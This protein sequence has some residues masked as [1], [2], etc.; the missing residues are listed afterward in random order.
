[1]GI[2]G[3]TK[4]RIEIMNLGRVINKVKLTLIEVESDQRESPGMEV[5]IH[6][7]EDAPYEPQVRIIKKGVA[8]AIRAG[9]L[10]T[11]HTDEAVEIGDRARF[12]ALPRH[13]RGNRPWEIQVHVWAT[14][15]VRNQDSAG[16]GQGRYHTW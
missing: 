2:D 6:S 3:R 9:P 7:L 1:M 5:S 4:A 8:G 16:D 11:D 14:E 13:C 10:D 12:A 15:G